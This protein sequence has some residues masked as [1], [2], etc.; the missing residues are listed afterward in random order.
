[1]TLQR[2]KPHLGAIL[3]PA[4]ALLLTL[5]L[6]PHLPSTL[7]VHFGLSGHPDRWLPLPQALT[8]WLGL[9]FATAG[10]LTLLP[11]LDPFWSRIRDRYD[12]FL[13]VRDTV[14]LILFLF[15]LLALWSALK[16]PSPSFL[17]AVIGGMCILLGNLLPRIPRNFFFGIRTPWTL[18]SERVW[19][20]THRVA[21]I[22]MMV[23]GGLLLAGS[24]MGM[25]PRMGWV[26]L[27]GV[28]LGI[29]LIYPYVLFRRERSSDL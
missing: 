12:V 26:L 11:R 6:L 16:G 20:K 21:G 27:F 5:L 14:L 4:G 29:G 8:L 23:T 25:P 9:L 10:V 18:A 19:R 13:I 2:W 28:S 7:P 1:M 15:Y 17:L 22:A 3:I 24:W